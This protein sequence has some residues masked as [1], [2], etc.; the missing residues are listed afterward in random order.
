M[1]L[2][3]RLPLRPVGAGRRISA[4]CGPCIT[5]WELSKTIMTAGRCSLRTANLLLTVKDTASAQLN[6][7]YQWKVLITSFAEHAEALSTIRYPVSGAFHSLSH[8]FFDILVT[9]WITRPSDG[10]S[11]T[12]NPITGSSQQLSVSQHWSAHQMTGQLLAYIHLSRLFH[13]YM[14]RQSDQSKTARSLNEQSLCR[15]LPSESYRK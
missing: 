4:V 11:N 12:V 1:S 3:R 8:L 13:I 6:F 2:L 14:H 15:K 9:H 5:L 7:D 10:H